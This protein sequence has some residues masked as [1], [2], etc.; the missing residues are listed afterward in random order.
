MESDKVQVRLEWM[1][2]PLF[3]GYTGYTVKA[4]RRKIEDGIWLEGRMFRR[5]PDGHITIN[6]QEYYSWVN[7]GARASLDERRTRGH[8][9]RRTAHSALRSQATGS[10]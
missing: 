2:L 1:L 8:D 10:N 4:V 6:L 7:A 3:C 5:A 9:R